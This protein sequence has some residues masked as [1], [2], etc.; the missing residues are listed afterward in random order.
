MVDHAKKALMEN[1]NTL[2]VAPTGAGKTIMLSVIVKELLEPAHKALIL[3]HTDEIFQQNQQKFRTIDPQRRV[4]EVNA[5]QKDFSGQ[6][7]F[8][9]VQSLHQDKALQ[10]M[11]SVDLLVIDE[12]HHAVAPTYGK[13]IDQAYHLN[14]HLKLLG[15]T[16]TPTRADQHGLSPIFSNIADHISI[17]ELVASGDL[18]YPKTFVI[19]TEVRDK[20]RKALKNVQGQENSDEDMEAAERAVE[21]IALSEIIKH[22]KEKAQGRK[23][24]IFCHRIEHSKELA[25]AFRKAGIKAK[26]IDG[27]CPLK[28]REDIL[29][30]FASGSIT[31]LCNVAVLTEGWD[32]PH[33]S[34]IILLRA[35]LSH[36]TMIQ[37]IGRGLR[38]L[39]PFLYPKREKKDCIV[40]DFG[41]SVTRHGSIE[42]KV[43]LL[44]KKKC[45]ACKALIPVVAQTCP[46]CGTDQMKKQHEKAERERLKEEKRQQRI[47]DLEMKEFLLQKVKQEKREAQEQEQQKIH[48]KREHDLS[49]YITKQ[50][51][52]Q[53]NLQAFIGVL[54]NY[55][56][57]YP[58]MID[59]DF[60][61]KTYEEWHNSK[62]DRSY[63]IFTQVEEK[64]WIASGSASQAVIFEISQKKDA[65]GLLCM[66]NSFTRF[67]LCS[68]QKALECAEGFL[69]KTSPHFL[70]LSHEAWLEYTPTPNQLYTLYPLLPANR[71]EAAAWISY[72]LTK[73]KIRIMTARM[74][75]DMQE[76]IK[77][78]A[79]IAPIAHTRASNN[80]YSP[81]S[82]PI[83]HAIALDSGAKM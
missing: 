20:V 19:D 35:L 80:A 56:E 30:Q 57:H 66:Q 21:E 83:K 47:Q 26:H 74:L 79:L 60:I 55:V 63:L 31:V 44:P 62:A 11:P 28:Q 77:D 40:L 48:E 46:A 3:Q 50:K 23:T 39:N 25:K 24:V 65:Y 41:M 17:E 70:P 15:M 5:A 73:E 4:S 72:K 37:M 10:K 27:T 78:A 68:Q 8:A 7:I 14:P 12:A 53:E 16:A 2:C 54:Q 38:V 32:A 71:R 6:V 76:N 58:Y 51:P 42:A 13:I 61:I 43:D 81:F 75:Q 9:M 64:V 49:Q 33:T 52:Y 82:C 1:G 36:P 34:C 22:W 45:I 67:I 59:K 69:R 18:L 29:S